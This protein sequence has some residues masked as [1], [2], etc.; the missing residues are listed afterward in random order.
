[1]LVFNSR[2]FLRGQ[3]YSETEAVNST[4]ITASIPCRE[5]YVFKPLWNSL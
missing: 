2:A 4:Y 3:K 5:H 1:M